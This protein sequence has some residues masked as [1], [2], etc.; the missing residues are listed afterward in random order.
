MNLPEAFLVSK[1]FEKAKN[2]LIIKGKTKEKLACLI[3]QAIEATNLDRLILLISI[4]RELVETKEIDTISSA[5]A[6]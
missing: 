5:Y 2:G 1:L 3:M 6:F 4:L